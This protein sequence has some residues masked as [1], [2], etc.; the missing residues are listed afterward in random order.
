MQLENLQPLGS[1]R[2]VT[3][4]VKPV[5]KSNR[6]EHPGPGYCLELPIGFLKIKTDERNSSG[7]YDST[8]VKEKIAESILKFLW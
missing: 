6:G 8:E 4:G 2:T 7:F 3:N 1:L 5:H